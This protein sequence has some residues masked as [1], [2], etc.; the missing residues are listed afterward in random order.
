MSEPVSDSSPA[1]GVT[2]PQNELTKQFT[3]TEWTT[4][5]E[6]RAKLPDIYRSAF[7]TEDEEASLRP[8][9]L[10][11]VEIDPVNPTKDAR[12]SV[13]LIKFLRAR[14]LDVPGAVDMLVATL[15]WR[16]E[17]K[18]DE[19]LS[20]EFPEDVFGGVGKVFGHDKEGRPV[21]YNV[22]G[23][24]LDMKPVFSD[25]KRFLRWRVQLMEKTIRLLDF[26]KHDQM[27]QVHD[28]EGVSF[29]GGR[30][31]NQ[32]AAASEASKIFQDNYPEFLANKYFI[33]VP[34]FATWIFWLF[35]PL[36]SAKTFAKMNVVGTGVSTVSAALLPAIGEAELPERYGGQ[37]KAF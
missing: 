6:L 35:K 16:Q 30:D 32:K 37:A 14:E 20:E 25:V 5:K 31:A 13:V 29:M 7:T 33:N 4:L 18:T 8:F 2:E 24:G 22:Y 28:Y 3:D 11:G 1:E 36:L 12:V 34:T 15:K 26:E 10:W 17:F 9:D 23:G 19:L 27:I 21:T